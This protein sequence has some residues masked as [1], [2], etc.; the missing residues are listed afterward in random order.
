LQNQRLYLAEFQGIF[1]HPHHDGG[2]GTLASIEFAPQITDYKSIGAYRKFSVNNGWSPI[3]VC[4]V[5]L[6]Y[7]TLLRQR[8]AQAGV[9]L[10]IAETMSAMR[11][12]RTALYWLPGE[13]NPRRQLEEPTATQLSILK[14]FG[15]AF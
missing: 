7:L 11:E 6:T 3:F 5:A 9:T 14:A 10:S 15:G 1:G 8:L 2:D 12:L 4:M 13:R